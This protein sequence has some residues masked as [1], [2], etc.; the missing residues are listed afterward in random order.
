MRL[1]I[2]IYLHFE[3]QY[4]SLYVR[5]RPSAIACAHPLFAVFRQVDYPVNCSPKNMT[6]YF[7]DASSLAI[8]ILD[9]NRDTQRPVGKTIIE[10]RDFDVSSP[11][12]R[13]LPVASANGK[14]LGHIVVGLHVSYL[15]VVSSF[16]MAEHLAATDV[17]L[18]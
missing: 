9:A 5:V 10:L 11:L 6:R 1:E 2:L 16:E 4:R 3:H 8:E 14:V 12:D 18:P 15:P 17:T 13:T 7:H